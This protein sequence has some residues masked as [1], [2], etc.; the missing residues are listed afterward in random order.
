MELVAR[1]CD[2]LLS[3]WLWS[4]TFD[5]YHIPINIVF[6]FLGLTFIVGMRTIRALLLSFSAHVFSFA[7]FTAI[8][9][10]ALKSGLEWVPSAHSEQIPTQGLN[11]FYA[12]M[13]L[14]AIHATLQSIFLLAVMRWSEHRT[15][16]AIVVT[17]ISNVLSGL[18]SYAGIIVTMSYV[19]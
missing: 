9:V 2:F 15:L 10:G 18:I 17:W 3:E 13:S 19:F 12:S 7:V 16:S 4:M 14:G 8:V 11:F 6:L 1:L 5:L